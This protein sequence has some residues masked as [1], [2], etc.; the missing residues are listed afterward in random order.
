MAKVLF[1][2]TCLV[3]GMFSC[4]NAAAQSV[5]DST[6]SDTVGMHDAKEVVISASRW[7]EER[8]T[9]SREI[10]TVTPRQV[11]ERD[12]ATTAEAL[13][14][15]GAIH[16]QKSQLGGGSP[17]LR[18]YAANAVLMVMDGVRINNAIYRG[19][20][21]Q[22][23]ISVDASSLDGIEVLMGPGSVQ[24]GSDAL[25]GVMNFQTRRPAHTDSA[26]AFHGSAFTRYGTA[27]NEVS[28]S[29]AMDMGDDVIASSTVISMSTFGDLAGGRSFMSA[30]PDFGRRPWYVESS[31]SSSIDTVVL[32]PNDHVQVP[33]GYDQVNILEN[34]ALKLNATTTLS[35]SGLF[36]TSPTIPRYDRLV[37]QR[38]GSPRFA[39]WNYG[40]QT[41]TLHALRVD[42]QPGGAIAD[43][44]AAIASF[45]YYEES[46]VERRFNK[47]ER[48]EQVDQ[49]LV[50]A[51][52]I[53]LQKRLADEGS[54]ELDLYY[55]LETN[56]NDVAS[57]A[58][59]TNITTNDVA[60][61]L[62]RYPDGGSFVSSAAAYAQVRA[63]LSDD[64]TIA[65]G[66]RFTWYDLRSTIADT[67]RYPYASTGDI[68][69]NASAVTGSLGATWIVAPS[70]TL[71]ANA[72]SGFRAPNVD[73]IAKI[74]DTAPGLLVIPNPSL[75][76]E[77][78]YTLEGGLEWQPTRR[79]SCAV[80]GYRTWAV[81][82]IERRA[83]T[84]NGM[85]T[86]DVG[87]VPSA[88]YTN[89]NVGQ[90]NIYGVNA[91]VRMERLFDRVDVTATATFTD[92]R[93]VTND[94]PLRHVPP[95]FGMVRVGWRDK[96]LSGGIEFWWAAAKPFNELPPEE[97]AK[98]GINYTED[99]TPAWQ[100]VD[101][102][103]SVRPAM[104]FTLQVRLENLLDLNYHTFASAISSP[105]RNLVISARLT[106]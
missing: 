40:P 8:R 41:W 65:G 91:S 73:D 53:D 44:V 69:V 51:I 1:L 96:V 68:T 22:N 61:G 98:V 30:Y 72:A 18:G 57:S 39:E 88:I 13:A 62:T 19:G 24:Y 12:P 49:V 56:V 85:D 23:V 46:R 45:Q 34:L 27:M 7:I 9:V 105:G 15:T 32:N 5:E 67:A 102:A 59:I 103:A 94:L 36:T 43:R 80:N 11:A 78:S 52:N 4:S 106:W 37:Q 29:V 25:G 55:G 79:V 90:A 71:H 93:D 54:S 48:S 63:G 21:L 74:F 66:L 97:Q 84:F 17:M 87:G 92:G 104:D 58:S 60:A 86:V 35:Y 2:L 20:N 99:G 26:F 42:A 100:R 33:T 3:A 38:N 77:Y 64:L 95:V 50:G 81:D 47:P 31:S 10:L 14:G 83:T 70:L 82:A 76:P 6:G 75:A 101:L 16:V 28:A 89:V